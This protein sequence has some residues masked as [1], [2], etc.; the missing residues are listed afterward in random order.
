MNDEIKNWNNRYVTN[1]MPWNSGLPSLQLATILK[2][3]NINPCRALDLGCGTGTNSLFLAKEGFEVTGVDCAA[4]ALIIAQK[5]SDEEGQQIDFIETDL[6]QWNP[7][8]EPFNFIFDR[9]CFHCVRKTGLEGF[10]KMLKNVSQS[11]T[12][13]LALTGNANDVEQEHGPPQ[14]T[15][16]EIENDLGSLFEIIDLHEFHF[17]DADHVQGPLGWSA[18][19]RRK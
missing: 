9:G 15:K 2:K 14:L 19:M 13:Y 12:Y 6:S 11:G 18:L 7:Q 17:E 3:H 16:E 5:R 10:L 1:D 8:F 4:E